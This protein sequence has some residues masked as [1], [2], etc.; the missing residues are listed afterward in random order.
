MLLARPYSDSSL[1]CELFTRHQGR[2]GVIA[3]GARGPKSKQR[4]LLQPAQPLLLS[5]KESGDLGTLTAVESAGPALLLAGEKVFFVWYLNELLLKLM[6]RH[7]PHDSLFDRY[8]EALERLPTA[9]AESGLRFFEKHLLAET[10]YGLHLETD[11]DPDG[12]YRYD[13]E[14]GPVSVGQGLLG[15]SLMALRDETPLDARG[16]LDARKLLRPLLAHQLAGRELE[17]P[18]LL[19]A[20]RSRDKGTAENE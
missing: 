6:Q 13:P 18:K 20:M 11:L 19:R 7:D 8:I 17:T 12:D 1:L 5:W 15:R 3:K 16:L 14:L 4:A 9:S 10:G 2:C